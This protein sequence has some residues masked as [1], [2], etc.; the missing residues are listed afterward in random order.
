MTDLFF[1]AVFK[2]VSPGGEVGEAP[3][4]HYRHAESSKS[5]VLRC[6]CSVMHYWSTTRKLKFPKLAIFVVNTGSAADFIA[7]GHCVQLTTAGENM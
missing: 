4:V 6:S 1:F 2:C 7:A 3:R 5:D